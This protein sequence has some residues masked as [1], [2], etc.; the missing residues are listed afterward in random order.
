MPRIGIIPDLLGVVERY[1]QSKSETLGHV[2]P[3]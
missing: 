1:F 3:L 2:M